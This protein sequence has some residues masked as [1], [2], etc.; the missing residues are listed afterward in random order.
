MRILITG[1]TGFIGTA[2]SDSLQRR[3]HTLRLGVRDVA[4]A[5]RRWPKADIVALDF[6]A[7]CDW[8]AAIADV[9]VVINTVGIIAGS[10]ARFDAVHASGAMA[11]FNAARAAGV[12]RILHFSALGSDA[13]LTNFQRTKHRAER[14]LLA[15]GIDASVLQPSLVFGANGKSAQF[16]LKL[17]AMRVLPLPRGGEQRIQPVHIDDVCDAVQRLVNAPNVPRTL[18][19]VGPRCITVAAYIAG[20]RRSL[21]RKPARALAVA[22]WLAR[23]AAS[24]GG[25]FGAPID[26][27]RLVMLDHGNCADATPLTRL[28]GREPRDPGDFISDARDVD[29]ELRRS[30]AIEWVRASIVAVWLISG[31]VSLG[32]WPRADSLAML[33]RCGLAGDAA[34]WALDGSALLDIAFGI[35]TLIARRARWL[36]DL[37]ILLIV[38]Y[39]AIIA[40]CMPEF[41]LHPFA[42]IVKNLVMLAGIA[43]LRTPARR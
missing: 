36:Y 41:L 17:S 9:D 34:Q 4:S 31:I 3:G 12:R 8:D 15:S 5:L 11:L 33:A 39:S 42:P 2:L 21:G 6:A 1:A 18:A 25:R 38:G 20:L 7:E 22:P 28:L 43:L 27:D 23:A 19:L 13:E 26:R 14:A 10:S 30:S 24:V 29:A 32:V 37:Q 40:F 35:A 16:F